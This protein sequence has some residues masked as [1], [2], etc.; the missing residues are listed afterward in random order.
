MKHKIFCMFFCLM[1]LGCT[2]K[3]AK[4]AVVETKAV[5]TDSIAIADTLVQASDSLSTD[6][7]ANDTAVIEQEKKIEEELVK[8]YEKTLTLYEVDFCPSSVKEALERLV[9]KDL[10]KEWRDKYEAYYLEIFSDN[11]TG[12]PYSTYD[13]YEKA[14]DFSNLIGYAKIDG[15]LMLIKDYSKGEFKNYVL[16]HNNPIQFTLKCIVVRN[17]KEIS[18]EILMENPVLFG[19]EVDREF[20]AKFDKLPSCDADSI[21]N[22][23]FPGF[24]SY[25][26]KEYR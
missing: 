8:E 14:Y 24:W 2:S 17:W 11:L 1:M 21:E 23:S 9:K 4:H 15:Y 20:T 6:T 25:I 26:G 19:E 7:V 5:A 22:A 10:Y 18:R 12:R 16:T 13:V 3:P